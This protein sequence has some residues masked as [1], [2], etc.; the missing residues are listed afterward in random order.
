MSQPA[1]ITLGFPWLMFNCHGIE[2]DNELIDMQMHI[3]FQMYQCKSHK[4]RGEQ[5]SQSQYL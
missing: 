1:S 4:C 2:G 5:V 3:D